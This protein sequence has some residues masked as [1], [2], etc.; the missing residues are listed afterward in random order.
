MDEVL[1]LLFIGFLFSVL[2]ICERYRNW[3]GPGSGPASGQQ[4]PRGDSPRFRGRGYG[5]GGPP[6]FRGRGGPPPMFGRGGPR[7]G[8]FNGPPSFNGPN[9]PNWGP[10]GQ[11]NAPPNMM[12]GPGPNF[13][14]P[15]LLGG[16]PNM[17]GGPPP[18]MGSNQFPPGAQ[19]PP[20]IVSF[21]KLITFVWIFI[22]LFYR[23]SMLKFGWRQN[24]LMESLIIIMP[25]QGKQH[26]QNLKVPVL[27]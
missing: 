22:N 7:N 8:N 18:L 19:Q 2:L 23:M 24:H 1:G 15:G 4:V 20:P 12:G 14:P 27:R 26:G 21:I 10:P 3:S 5:P 25:E 9:G 13:A 17:T 16:P 11:M 6:S